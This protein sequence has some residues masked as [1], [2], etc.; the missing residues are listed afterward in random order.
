VACGPQN[1]TPDSEQLLAANQTGQITVYNNCPA[2]PFGE[3]RVEVCRIGGILDCLSPQLV[4]TGTS[5]T[6]DVLDQ[7]GFTY[8]VKGPDFIGNT[9]FYSP[10]TAKAGDYV[11]IIGGYQNL[12]GVSVCRCVVNGLEPPSPG[13]IKPSAA[14]WSNYLRENV[15]K[16]PQ[17]RDCVTDANKTTSDL[18]GG[19]NCDKCLFRVPS[20]VGE[21]CKVHEDCQGYSGLGKAG[22]A[23]CGGRCDN[24]KKDWAGVYYCPADCVGAPFGKPGSC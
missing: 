1:T 22:V 12:L 18:C 24:L 11:E 7:A 16:Y 10:C 19:Y 13:Q 4:K 17:C 20:Q 15:G 8:D 21:L 5:T 9:S 14:C 6:F 2:I 3:T 23:C